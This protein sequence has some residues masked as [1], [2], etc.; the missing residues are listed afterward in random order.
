MENG[1]KSKKGARITASVGTDTILSIQEGQERI[2]R[3]PT[4]AEE[5]VA[6]ALSRPR[7]R[8]PSR[9]SR[10]LLDCWAYNTPLA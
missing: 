10:C 4:Q 5:E 2:E 1:Q 9:C 7:Q 8:A 6:K 3:R